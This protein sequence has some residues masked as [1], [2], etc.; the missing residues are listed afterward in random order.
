MTVIARTLDGSS[1]ELPQNAITSLA[2]AVRGTVIVEA[3]PRYDAARA[4]WNAMIDCR[5][6]LIVR[7]LG[8]GD[9]ITVVNFARER[10]LLLAIRGG[11]H[12]VAGLALAAG[13][14]VLDMSAMR[15]VFVNRENGVAH[16]QAGCLLGD[17][18]RETQLHGLATPLGFV[19]NTGIAGLTLGGGFGYLTRHYGWSCDNVE[20]FQVVTAQGKLVTASER[21]E[22]ELFW[23]L[24]GGG[25]NFGAV[26]DFE[27]KLYPV[28][29]EITGGAVAWRIEDAAEVLGL[30]RQLCADAPAEM[31]CN[32][33]FRLASPAPWLDRSVHGKPIVLFTVCDHGPLAEAEKRAKLIKSFGKPV[34][35]ILVRRPYTAIQSL[36]DAAQPSGRRY[37]QKAEYV[38]RVTSELLEACLAHVDRIQSP[39]TVLTLFMLSGKINELP[40]GHSAVGNRTAGCLVS[41]TSAWDAAADD[42]RNIEWAR[43][44]WEACRK[45]ST[46]GTYVNLLTEEETDQR[47][48]DAYGANYQRL[49]EAKTKYDPQNLFRVNKNIAPR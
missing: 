40:Q 23:A 43:A 29:P 24:R 31:V 39:H 21:S 46:G 9:V 47:T 17:V 5:P 41:I 3:D 45:F 13:A 49:V 6:A 33:N 12:N 2:A 7:C 38:E 37:Y 18:D 22:P 34:G 16:A 1:V 42:A 48:H 4:L 19:S 44:T 26:T 14:I 8:T 30:Y 35:D 10:G 32:A 27:Y 15:G 28:G 25:G 36:F 20:S 11:G